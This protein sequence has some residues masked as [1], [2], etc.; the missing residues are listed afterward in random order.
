MQDL[1]RNGVFGSKSGCNSPI[2]ALA[3]VL[4]SRI[5]SVATTYV[6]HTLEQ[7]NENR[8]LS[9][10]YKDDVIVQHELFLALNRLSICSKTQ[11]HK[12]L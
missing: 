3:T 1:F 12:E 11:F 4:L 9:L 6:L 8:L 5:S 10:S 7:Q 2:N